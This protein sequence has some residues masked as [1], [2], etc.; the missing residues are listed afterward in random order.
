MST[1]AITVKGVEY[2]IP[3]EIWRVACRTFEQQY[4]KGWARPPGS[5]WGLAN[6]IA[7]DLMPARHED[8]FSEERLTRCLLSHF[9][10][11]GGKKQGKKQGKKGNKKQ[12]SL[13]HGQM[14]LPLGE[15]T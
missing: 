3:E 7:S 11:H 10:K 1:V 8:P 5:I 15:Q 6:R 4:S 13:P 9:G 2:H 14:D 12:A